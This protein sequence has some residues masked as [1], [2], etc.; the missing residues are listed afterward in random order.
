MHSRILVTSFLLGLISLAQA[1]VELDTATAEMREI[2]REYRLDGVVEAVNQSTLSAQTQG[3]V[4]AV[5]FDVDDYVER[6][7][8]IIKLK[9]TEQRAGL[10]KAEANLK[11]ARARAREA[12]DEQKRVKEIYTK[13]LVSQAAMDKANTA[14]K[15]ALA[16]LEAAKANLTQAR[17]QLEYTRIRAPFSG[18]VTHRHIEVGEIAHPGQRLMSGISLDKLRVNVDVPQS[19]I[20]IVRKINKASIELP[21][22]GYVPASKITIFPFAHHGSNTFKVRLDLD[23]HTEN[24]FPG[25]FVKTSFIV[26]SRKQLLVPVQAVVYRSEVTGVYVVNKTGKIT[27]RHIRTGHKIQTGEIIVLSGLQ[28]GEQVALDP[29]AA[30]TQ[31]KAQLESPHE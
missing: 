11:S 21:G 8:L 18:I 12:A 25:M 24:L 29:I 30:G 23:N 15:S 31:L 9:D 22:Y 27:L 4:E 7:A 6:G 1:G 20:P 14:L 5:L 19:L 2:P 16:A 13:K 10:A 17:E 28:A 3:Q 26:G